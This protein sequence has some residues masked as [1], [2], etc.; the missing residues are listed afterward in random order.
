MGR[1]YMTMDTWAELFVS[2]VPLGC[3]DLQGCPDKPVLA[4]PEP[5]GGVLSVT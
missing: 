5:A 1:G 2:W 4:T 3:K